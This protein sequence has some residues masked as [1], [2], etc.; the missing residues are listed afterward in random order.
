M[1]VE[2]PREATED[3]VIEM[4]E[5][6]RRLAP[7]GWRSAF[8]ARA[9]APSGAAAAAPARRARN[10][11]AHEHWADL[12]LRPRL[13]VLLT[14]LEGRTLFPAADDLGAAIASEPAERS[15]LRLIGAL[16]DGALSQPP[17]EAPA[18]ASV[19]WGEGATRFFTFPSHIFR[20]EIR[21]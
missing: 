11:L 3:E 20:D 10:P 4:A 2:T 15:R 16:P 14:L 18:G 19:A 5:W 7:I 8:D 6:D 17:P 12:P 9:E 1:L 13:R 21:V